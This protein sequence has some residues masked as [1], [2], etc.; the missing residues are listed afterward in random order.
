MKGYI[1]I[2]G[3][4]ADPQVNKMMKDPILRGIPTLGACM[5]NIRRQ[6]VRGDWIFVVSGKTAGVQQYVVG[7]LQVDEKISA[8]VAH[9]RFP[10][11]RLRKE[12]DGRMSGNIIVDGNGRKHVLDQHR[13]ANFD[14][15]IQDYIVGSQSIE[16]AREAEI[17]RSRAETIRKLADIFNRPPGN[18][19]VDVIG[20]GA[21]KM[22]DNQVNGLLEWLRGIQAGANR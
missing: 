8:L 7:G 16:L 4:G 9:D 5:P 15:R 11:Y 19:V 22:D 13:D 20:R 12:D 18:R 6:V 17:A 14:R 21:R 3:Q 2:T 10:D 1:Y